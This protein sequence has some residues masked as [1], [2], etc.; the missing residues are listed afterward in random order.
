M[1][2][3]IDLNAQIAQVQAMVNQLNPAL[4]ELEDAVLAAVAGPDYSPEIALLD[5]ML[6]G[7]Q[8]ALSSI[9]NLKN[10]I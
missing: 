10:S 8:A 6:T 9:N 1:A 4:N 2:N 7:I 3:Q 5:N